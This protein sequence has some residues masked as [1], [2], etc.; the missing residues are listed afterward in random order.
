MPLDR[1][2][3]AGAVALTLS[4]TLGA[5]TTAAPTATPVPTVAADRT[6]GPAAAPEL[7]AM[8]PASA[9]GVDFVS[10]SFTGEDLAGVGVSLDSAELEQLAKAQGT[11]L[12]DVQVA[13]ARPVDSSKGGIILAIR[14]PGANPKE[15]VEATYSASAAL[16]LATMG[17]KAVYEVGG[18]GLNIVVY[19]KDDI[20]FQVV[21]A[22]SDLTEAI[23]AAL[24]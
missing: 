19:P 4:L 16:R 22:P 24:P 23:I 7:A 20:L 12:A 11:T 13:E 21:G 1:R 5:C 8:L 2:V 10:G 14:V 6:P 3:V 15:V 18:S 9:G 17:G